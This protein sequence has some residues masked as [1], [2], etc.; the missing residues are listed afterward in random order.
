[1]GKLVLWSIRVIMV[2]IA[3]GGFGDGVENEDRDSGM[4]ERCKACAF[5]L[6][7]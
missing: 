5:F 2:G 1:M 6:F 7:V 4:Y 3:D